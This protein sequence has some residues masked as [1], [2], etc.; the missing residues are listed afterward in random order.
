VD[1]TDSGR[2]TTRR[3]VRLFVS[4]VGR[5]VAKAVAGDR[6][7]PA[8]FHDAIAPELAGRG[9]FHNRQRLR[10]AL[11]CRTPNGHLAHTESMSDTATKNPEMSRA[12]TAGFFR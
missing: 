1:D 7:E 12:A 2:A 8:S 9:F 6:T 5:I 3:G 11:D 10:R 4:T